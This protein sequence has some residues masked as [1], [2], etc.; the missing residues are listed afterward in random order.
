[1][2]YQNSTVISFQFILVFHICYYLLAS[3]I[4]FE[5]LTGILVDFTETLKVLDDEYFPNIPKILLIGPTSPQFQRRWKKVACSKGQ[6]KLFLLETCIRKL[7][8]K[9]F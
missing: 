1:M 6:M 2:N 9:L 4:L 5:K 3:F 7:R 8:G